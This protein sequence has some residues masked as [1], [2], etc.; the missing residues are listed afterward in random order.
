MVKAV[1]QV[2]GKV[3]KKSWYPILATKTFD[4]A[5]LGE[6]YVVEPSLLL[7]RHLTLNLAN[8]TG[9]IKQQGVSLKFLISET[10]DKEG[11][12]TVM[13]YE[14]S[15]S[16]LK[17]LVRRGVERLD[18]VVVC[19]TADKKMVTVK[20][21][22]VTRTAASKHKLSLMRKL[23]RESITSEVKKQ[24]F[25]ELIRVVISN[26]FQISLK[27]MVK[28][29][30]PLKALEI[31]KLQIIQPKNKTDEE[32]MGTEAK[33][34][35]KA[36]HKK[37]KK[38]SA[39]TKPVKEEKAVEQKTAE[40]PKEEPA[41]AEPTKEEPVKQEKALEEP[42]KEEPAKAEPA[43]E[44]PV[45]QEKT[46]EE[47]RKEEPAKAETTKQEKAPEETRKEEP[48]KAE[49]TKQEKAPEET[50]KEASKAEE[51]VTKE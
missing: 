19:E 38:E 11:I 46:P 30:F 51:P 7:N 31:R 43:K 48:A 9:D 36:P 45:K 20:P 21:F 17:R 34:P 49:T 5:F 6:S 35:A 50:R 40:A 39:E 14:A 33:T 8:L 3:L 29:L 47:T 15:P 2:K 27:T 28:K 44:E 10:N 23:L 12:A 16:Q 42:K 25:D 13:S 37:T 18:D 26:K 4:S 22:A 32:G 41:K 1:H 24:T